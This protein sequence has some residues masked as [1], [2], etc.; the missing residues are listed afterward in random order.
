[1][2]RWSP[3]SL[4]WHPF[5]IAS[6]PL[7]HYYQKDLGG[8]LFAHFARMLGLYLAITAGVLLVTRRLWRETGRADL[9]CA[10]SVGTLFYAGSLEWPKLAAAAMVILALV[11]L[12]Q[13]LA[14][15]L[16][17]WTPVVNVA[18][19]VLVAFPIASLARMQWSWRSPTVIPDA[20]QVEAA[21]PAPGDA[22]DD[23][24]DI[25][26]I[27]AD[28][29]ASPEVFERWYGVDH[30]SLEAPMRNLGFHVVPGSR[31]NYAQTALSFAATLNM[32]YVQ[33]L[34]DVRDPNNNDRRPLAGLIARSRVVEMLRARGYHI[35]SFPSEYDLAQLAN[36]DVVR[37][38]PGAPGFFALHT[39]RNTLLPHVQRLLGRGPGDVGFALHRR[40]IEYVLHE[41]PRV[42][43]R[44]PATR[45]LF[46]HAHVIAPHPPFVWDRHGAPLESRQRF[47]FSDG[48]HWLMER[49]GTREQYVRE[50]RDQALYVVERLAT[51][52]A[53]IVRRSSRPLVIVVQGDHGPGSE[54]R[55][56]DLESTASDERHGIF[57]A[58]LTTAQPTTYP[59]PGSTAVN[60]FRFLFDAYLGS[61]MPM[62]DDRAWAST[63]RRPYVFVE[64]PITQAD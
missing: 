41:L 58:W 63:W 39:L 34:L 59:P 38:P 1:M 55:W 54:L 14:A 19:V 18:C 26:Y 46:V 60:T 50:Y 27:V 21:A 23:T 25:Y 64:L 16:A 11:L 62:L 7:L 29:L 53:E 56:D 2:K 12:P 51:T 17:R 42:R 40:R 20:T 31:S 47:A 4:P 28:G 24:P 33:E 61:R 45:P 5:L 6:L 57:N 8:S 32:R 43:A 10:A 15:R 48:D 44:V 35:E 22:P 13:R 30:D 3:S 36:A 9:V 37:K 52:V 49:H